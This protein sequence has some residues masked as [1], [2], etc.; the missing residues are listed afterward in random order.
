M[1]KK[2]NIATLAPKIELNPVAKE[3]K[4]MIRISILIVCEG[5]KTEP[6]YFRAFDSMKNSSGYVFNITTD[7]G[8][9]NTTQVVD[10]AIEMRDAAVKAGKPFD[11]V[12]AV[13]DKDN[14]DSGDFDNAI[15]KALKYGIGC[16]WSNEAFELWY[17]YHFDARITSMSRKEYKNTIT[18]RVRKAGYRRNG[19]AFVYKKNDNAMR[20]ILSECNCDEDVA[21]RNAENQANSFYDQKFHSHNPCTM[22]YKLVKILTG[23]DK[24]FN[25]RIKEQVETK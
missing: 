16:A 24:D 25:K 11:S 22:V 19:K 13:F 3:E 14:F 8:R 5:E 6:N 10:K 17:I 9:I 7:G 15:M 20:K 4:H 1:A 18:N 2:L 12:W 23:K 21:I